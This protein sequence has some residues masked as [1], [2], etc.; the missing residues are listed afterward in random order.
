M[1]EPCELFKLIPREKIEHIF[2]TSQT[3]GAELDYTFLGFE[4]V[5]KA[6]TL[7]VPKIK[8]IIDLGCGYAFQSWYFRDYKKYI[9]VDN[10]VCLADTLETENSEFYFTSIQN[11]V[12]NV[13]QQL[14]YST[15]EVFAICSYVPDIN[16]R[17]MVRNFFP[18]C[19]VYY[20]TGGDLR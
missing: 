1:Q 20:P 2:K 3:A 8:V 6:V 12:E 5:Y 9:G 16:A 11:F 7:F 14:G 10:G 17:E 19:L 13:F 15:D 4:D 18:Y